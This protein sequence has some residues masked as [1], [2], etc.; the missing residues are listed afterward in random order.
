MSKLL[1]SVILIVLVLSVAA[2]AADSLVVVGPLD[3][4][5]V[6]RLER[7]FPLSVDDYDGLYAYC[8]LRAADLVHLEALP[9]EWRLLVADTRAVNPRFSTDGEGR[10]EP[11]DDF[12]TYAESIALLQDWAADP[13]YDDICRYVD[14][15]LNSLEGRELAA[16][17]ISDNVDVEEYE[18]EVRVVG[19]HHGNE[20]IAN[21]VT[22]Y[23]AERLLTGYV[24]GDPDIVELV[25]GTEIWLQPLVNPDGYVASSRYNDNDVD[26]NRNYSYQW[27][28]G[29]GHGSYPFS[30]PETQA[31]ADYS[32]G[33]EDHVPDNAE[34]NAFVLGLTHHSGAVCVNY[35]WNYTGQDAP[36]KNHIWHN[37][38]QSYSDG[39]EESPYYDGLSD[40][41]YMDWITEGWEWYETHGDLNDWSYGMRGCIDTTIELSEG[42]YGGHPEGTI[43]ALCDVNWEATYNYLD[44]ADHGLHGLCTD[45]AGEPVPTLI[46][47]DNRTEAFFYNDP[48]VHGDYWL[49]LADGTYD[50]T[51]SAD[52]YDPVILE[53]VVVDGENTPP[54][55]IEFIN[56]G[57]TGPEPWAEL[58]DEGVLL[59]WNPAGYQSYNVYRLGS[60]GTTIGTRLNEHPLPG[61]V[62]SFLDRQ[63]R[64]PVSRYRLEAVD[65]AGHRAVFGA[66]EISLPPEESRIGLALYPNPTHDRVNLEINGTGSAVVELYDLAGR[67]LR[68]EE[69]PAGTGSRTLSWNVEN[70]A[71]GLYL[72]SLRGP[73]TATTRRLIID[74]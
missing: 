30:E 64:R 32:G 54:L 67:L 2:G 21:E 37:I 19:T 71:A 24:A 14:L 23:T 31:V 13:D 48:T 61:S 68:A 40:P 8:Y 72:V 74:R 18:P 43:L 73:N 35:V 50:I 57:T 66:V 1:R 7:E 27:E 41:D 9:W 28:S 39:C 5:E 33:D 12:H 4:D 51:F 59:R 45:G 55:D 53:G 22:L 3:H 17:V 15:G 44:W 42:Q 6:P 58:C 29:Y 49:T 36:D 63:P 69:L 70:L 56:T 16:I 60:R 26:L 47:V 52:G 62:V 10:D 34:D 65:A 20:E 25:E 46:T 11:W 38:S